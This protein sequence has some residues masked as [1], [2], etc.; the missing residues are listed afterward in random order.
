MIKHGNT[1]PPVGHSRW[2][3]IAPFIGVSRETWR[4]LCKTGRAPE[5]IRLSARCTVW[6]NSEIHAYLADPLGY[7]KLRSRRA[8]LG[9]ESENDA[10]GSLR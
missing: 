7:G 8:G 2:G 9:V 5:P 3:Q 1:L 4:Q 6:K 10:S